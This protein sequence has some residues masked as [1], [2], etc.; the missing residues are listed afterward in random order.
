MIDLYT[1]NG[2]NNCV[3]AKNVLNSLKVEYRNF[4]VGIDVSREYV[5]EK[6]P[7]ARSYPIVIINGEFV[8][9][10]SEL[11]TKIVEHKENVGKLFLVG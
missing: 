1:K 5:L 3:K 7:N 2:C 11:E 8:G 10:Y 9:G 4:T 6:F